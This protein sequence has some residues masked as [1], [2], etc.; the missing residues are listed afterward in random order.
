[1]PVDRP[2]SDP[3]SLKLFLS[4]GGGA[5]ESVALD[6]TFVHSLRTDSILYV[7]VGLVRD[8]SGYDECYEWICRT[9][10][11][12]G[13]SLD[14]SMWVDLKGK[15]YSDIKDFSAI[16]IGGANNSYRLMGILEDSG[17]APL[18]RKF[19]AE[20]GMVYGGSTGAILMGK[21]ISI[22]GEEPVGNYTQPYGFGFAEEY[23]VFCHYTKQ[24]EIKITDFIGKYSGSVIGIPERSGVTVNS[25]GKATVVGDERVLLFDE[26]L[27]RKIVDV[28]NT[29]KL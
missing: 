20:G 14:I 3:N 24:R 10:N 5:K 11:A 17:F 21:Y 25:S 2:T 28:G 23:S 12:F 4:G 13:R 29:F 22:F 18:L 6:E 1:M 16:Y 27:N 26:R 8:L 19:F 9:L 15:S 7:P